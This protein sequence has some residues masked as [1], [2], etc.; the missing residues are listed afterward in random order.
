MS[1]ERTPKAASAADEL[2]S[3]MSDDSLESSV[4]KG[5]S[6]HGEVMD[7]PDVHTKNL[8]ST[9]LPKPSP[10]TIDVESDTKPKVGGKAAELLSLLKK[11]LTNK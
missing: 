3:G 5:S 11:Q 10:Q 9:I 4:V 6:E 2:D 8:V 7:R 1:S